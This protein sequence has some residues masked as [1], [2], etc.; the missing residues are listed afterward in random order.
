MAE[1]ASHIE[2]PDTT[3]CGLVGTSTV[4]AGDDHW[5]LTCTR[6]ECMAVSVLEEVEYL[7]T[8]SLSIAIP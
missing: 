3:E 2:L 5:R 4:T 7:L 8:A 1:Q 6:S